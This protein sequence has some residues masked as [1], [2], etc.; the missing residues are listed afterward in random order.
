MG[1]SLDL[2]ESR[3][4]RVSIKYLNTQN[5]VQIKSWHPSQ[6]AMGLQSK[7]SPKICWIRSLSFLEPKVTWWPGGGHW[8]YLDLVP[9]QL[10][11]S[12]MPSM[13]V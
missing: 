4:D 3:H 10:F 9:N 2:Y 1:I 13:Y 5:G 6:V 11:W 12:S 7:S 8:E